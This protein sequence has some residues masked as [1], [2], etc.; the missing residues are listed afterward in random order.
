ML[1]VFEDELIT[2]LKVLQMANTVGLVR[3]KGTLQYKIVKT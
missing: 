2:C 1:N 3:E